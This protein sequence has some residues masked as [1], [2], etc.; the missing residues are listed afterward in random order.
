MVIPPRLF[1]KSII[2][3]LSSFD[4]YLTTPVFTGVSKPKTIPN[5]FRMWKQDTKDDIDTVIQNDLN[6]DFDVSP[7]MKDPNDILN[8]IEIIKNNFKMIQ[9]V[10]MEM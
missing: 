8:G 3:N 2:V 6:G 9:T 5:V 1:C 7:F 10:F 4:Q